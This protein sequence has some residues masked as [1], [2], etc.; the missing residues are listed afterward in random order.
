M[1]RN[2]QHEKAL[3]DYELNGG[4]YMKGKKIA[5]VLLIAVM[6]MS[7]LSCGFSAFAILT[8]ETQYAYDAANLSWLKDLIIKEDMTSIGG[9]TEK[10]EFQAKSKYP[11]RET[12]ESFSEE[13]SY[14][15]ILYTLD[16]N[17]A[18]VAYLYLLDIAESLASSSAA[19]NYSD[20][21]IRSYL[22]SIGIVYPSGE[23]GNS[24]ETKIVA[25]AFF[26][27]ISNDDGYV[28]S[29]GTGLYEAFT[30]Y[31]STLLGVSGGAILKFDG[32]G[33]L[34]D[35]KEYVLAACKYVLFAAGYNVDANTPENEVYRLLAIMMIR[36]QGI[37]IDSGTAT[38]EE[39]KNKYLCAM[40]CK[41]YG[42]SADSASFDGAVKNGNLDFY[43]LQ[44]IGKKNGVTVKD[45]V[46]YSE[47][48]KLVCENTH[49]FDL[50]KGEFYADIYEYD[51]P[52]RYK[53]NAIWIYPQTLGVTSASDGTT[54]A[55][56]INGSRVRENYYSEV[57]L[58][59]S[60]AGETV[61]ISVEYTEG[62]KKISSSYQLNIIQGASSIVQPG[63]V[64]QALASVS[65]VVQKVLDEM[66][67][68]PSIGG[69]V[70]N[71]PFEL[72][73]R[74][75][76]V[77][78][79]LL[80]S[81]GTDSSGIGFLQRLFGYVRGNDSNVGTDKIGGVGGL[82]SFNSSDSALSMDFNKNNADVGNL[83]FSPL[84]GQAEIKPAD[85][86]VIPNEKPGY[87]Q[88]TVI[89]DNGNW[90]KDL[91]SD[92]PTVIVLSVVLV[93]TFGVC[94]VL[95]NQL[96]KGHNENSRKK[97]KKN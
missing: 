5:A 88:Q 66:G 21:F 26:A 38:F 3:R 42:V 37:S 81:F 76:N 74:F 12:A 39:I 25:R 97:S 13:I 4:E 71:I 85:S 89:N 79:L 59:P 52:L 64:S 27:V 56:S 22:E 70:K 65:D 41:I 61:I 58:D 24:T 51:V 28:V 96:I 77:S 91:I 73:E 19:A 86:F 82:D 62:G 29:R 54:V 60:K 46:S 95:F 83:Q 15:Q 68:N 93:L 18:N 78:S 57:K 1:N 7:I 36:A 33:D 43:M 11:Y 17:M 6:L 67:N 48:F 40:M 55:V 45:T 31:L 49:Y 72:P 63:T 44:L 94:F 14:Y 30:A 35:L 8:V 2:T 23:A 53:R 34:S 90:F 16:E 47:A 50:E 20:E 80:P 10:T 84:P 75:L 32:D 69:I 92:I 87:P 9:M